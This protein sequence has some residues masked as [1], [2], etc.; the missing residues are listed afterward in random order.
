MSK[1]QTEQ[2]A[3]ETPPATLEETFAALEPHIQ[4]EPHAAFFRELVA[5]MRAFDDRTVQLR[6]QLESVDLLTG[7]LDKAAF[8]DR[9]ELTGLATQQEARG[10]ELAD[11]VKRFEAFRETFSSDYYAL[12]TQLSELRE[13][14]VGLDQRLQTIETVSARLDGFPLDT[15]PPAAPATETNDAPVAGTHDGGASEPGAPNAT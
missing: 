7:A 14:M 11:L 5:R 4:W 13:L 1:E 12:A 3:E 10:V 9:Q 2:P 8:G 6:V 15:E